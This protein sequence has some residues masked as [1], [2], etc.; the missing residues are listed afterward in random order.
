MITQAILRLRPGA[1]FSVNG[2][3]YSGIIWHDENQTQPTEQE[4]LSAIEEIKSEW[5]ATEYVRQRREAYPLIGD[6][7]DALWKIINQLRLEGTNL[8]QE[9]DDLLNQILAVKKTYKKPE[10]GE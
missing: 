6:Q 2:E 10:A 9:G 4:I 1:S 8:P 7:L 5:K 3:V